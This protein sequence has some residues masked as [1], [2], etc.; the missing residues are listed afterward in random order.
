MENSGDKDPKTQVFGV[1]TAFLALMCILTVVGIAT[2]GQMFFKAWGGVEAEKTLPVTAEG[3]AK[4]VPDIA[5]ISLGVISRGD[6]AK[7]AQDQAVQ[8]I[9]KITAFVKQNGVSDQDITTSGSNLNPV[10]NWQDGKNE[11]NGYES[12]QTITVKVRSVNTPEG[13]EKASMIIAG[14]V[15]NGATSVYGSSFTIDDPDSY[16]QTARLEAIAKA[17]EKAKELADA[18]GI[19]LGKV[20]SVSESD[21]YYPVPMYADKAVAMEGI[22]G[23]AG[24]SIEPGEQDVIQRVTIVFE[25]K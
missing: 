8:A 13:K 16:R 11:I 5:T 24:P 23:G 1:L 3:K 19:K 7:K 10:Y 18:A 20:L 2:L 25:I 15:D 4:A 9:N 14:A 22:G 21:G 17:K 12:N 6:T